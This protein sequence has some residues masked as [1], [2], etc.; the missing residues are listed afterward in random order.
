MLYL[1]T[2]VEP[3]YGGK[4]PHVLRT[5]K[6]LRGKAPDWEADFCPQFSDS[7]DEIIRKVLNRE[8]YNT[9]PSRGHYGWMRFPDYAVE[10]LIIG[11]MA[12]DIDLEIIQWE[13]K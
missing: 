12:C 1:Y 5:S 10:R 8:D 6:D 7:E 4:R 11:C 9:P 2:H 3:H 13:V